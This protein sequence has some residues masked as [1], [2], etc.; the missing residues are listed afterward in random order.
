MDISSNSTAE[1]CCICLE[2]NDIV[3]CCFKD[4][5]RHIPCKCN[6]YCHKYCFEQTNTTHCMICKQEYTFSWGENPNKPK[7]KKCCVGCYKKTKKKIK[8]KY[9]LGKISLQ[10]QNRRLEKSVRN[11]MHK[12]YYP[13]F[14]NCCLDMCAATSYSIIVLMLLITVVVSALMVGGYY[15]NIILCMLFNL[16]ENTY[17]CLLPT[18][19]GMLYLLGLIGFP[20]LMCS[21]ACCFCCCGPLFANDNNKIFPYGIV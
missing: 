2:S 16:W 10:K 15:L 17:F 13:D 20:L 18:S 8:A 5:I 6:M 3:S 21:F 4:K 19:D 14:G 1:H 12:L 9:I 11:C 7:K